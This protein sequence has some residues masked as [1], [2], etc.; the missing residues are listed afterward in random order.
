MLTLE[1]TLAV[2][3]LVVMQAFYTALLGSDPQVVWADRYAGFQIHGQRLGLFRPR[4]EECDRWRSA[5]GAW[6][7]CLYVP[8]LEAACQTVLAAGGQI[9]SAAIAET[10]GR[11]C[12]A[13]DPE[14]NRLLLC[15]GEPPVALPDPQPA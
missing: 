13:R 14:G 8:D 2:Q 15:Q 9:E 7:L 3:N 11:E 10:Y 12:Y 1:M 6:S 4:R 5:Q